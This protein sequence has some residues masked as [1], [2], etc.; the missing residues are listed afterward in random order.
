M[1]SRSLARMRLGGLAQPAVEDFAG[2]GAGQY[3]ACMKERAALWPCRFSPKTTIRPAL[4]EKATYCGET[5][6][7]RMSFRR[8]TETSFSREAKAKMFRILF[9][10]LIE[11]KLQY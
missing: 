11:K 1:S 10:R 9:L 2:R 4:C 7:N 6:T 3:R 8:N 5:S